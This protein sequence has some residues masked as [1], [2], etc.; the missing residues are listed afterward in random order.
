MKFV[1]PLRYLALVAGLTSEA[2]YIFIPECPPPQDWQDRV[3]DKLQQASHF[4]PYFLIL[5]LLILS[6][7]PV[8][9]NEGIS[10]P[11]PL[12][13]KAGLWSRSRWSRMFSAG[14]GV[15]FLKLLESE[16]VFQNCWSRNL[17]KSSD[18]TTLFK[19]LLLHTKKTIAEEFT[20]LVSGMLI[21]ASLT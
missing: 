21:S 9:S 1:P 19:R 3:C 7:S 13:L 16:S 6:L 15:V 2:D 14:V 5:Y 17:K 4:L 10:C 8:L 20:K 12:P 11:T 18:S